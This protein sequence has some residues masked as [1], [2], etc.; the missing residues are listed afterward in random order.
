MGRCFSSAERSCVSIAFKHI[1]MHAESH[2]LVP[3]VMYTCIFILYFLT[4]VKVM[5]YNNIIHQEV[6]NRKVSVIKLVLPHQKET[7]HQP[8][9]D[10]RTFHS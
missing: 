1:Q 4:I 7:D 10:Q 9:I 8:L 5:F 6:C 3:F 2:E